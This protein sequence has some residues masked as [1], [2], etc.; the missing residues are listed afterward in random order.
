MTFENVKISVLY[1]SQT[2]NAQD[3]AEQI[4][5]ESK[6]FYFQSSIKALDDYNAADI[7]QEQCA[8]FVCSTTGQGDE[9]DNMKSFW[10]FLLRR[11]L[12]G[13]L[14]SGMK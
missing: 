14:L 7:D 5:R 11:S 12:P 2:G 8:I 4:W 9:P 1:G 10:R 6:R 3:L 13:T